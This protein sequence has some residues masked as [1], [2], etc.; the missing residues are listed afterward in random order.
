MDMSR[1]EL[2]HEGGTRFRADIRGHRVIFDQPPESGGEDRGPTPT[3]MFVASLAGCVGYHAERF[4][5]RHGKSTDGLGVH[6]TFVMGERP[7]RVVSVDLAVV[8]PPGL[9]DALRAPLLAV[10]EHCTVSTS[11]RLG[12]AVRI[13]VASGNAQAATPVA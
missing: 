12:P 7:A 4:L 3:E 13:S 9:E 6:A 2:V 5:E 10:V 1:I 11:I 8:V